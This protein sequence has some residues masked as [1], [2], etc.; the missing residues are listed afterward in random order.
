MFYI[1]VLVYTSKSNFFSHVVN[2]CLNFLLDSATN[3]SYLIF[4][5][6]LNYLTVILSYPSGL[7]YIHD[8]DP[9]TN[10]RVFISDSHLAWVV[11][12]HYLS[13]LIDLL[14]SLKYNRHHRKFVMF[15]R[16]GFSLLSRVVYFP[17][18][19]RGSTIK[20]L[21]QQIQMLV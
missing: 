5:F 17:L 21:W 15:L 19:C 13:I 14:S 10:W 11:Y 20:N 2:S 4:R 3:I 8:I 16:M 7:R 12:K 1:F 18:Y 6:Y 9:I